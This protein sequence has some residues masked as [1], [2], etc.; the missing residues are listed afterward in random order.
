MS[1]GFVQFLIFGE[2]DSECGIEILSLIVG[3]KGS[4]FKIYIGQV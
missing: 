1:C 2:L 4:F 3:L